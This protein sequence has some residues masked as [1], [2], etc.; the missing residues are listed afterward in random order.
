M[1]ADGENWNDTHPE[2][3]T[4][5]GIHD[6]CWVIVRPLTFHKYIMVTLVPCAQLP[7][8]QQ[9]FCRMTCISAKTTV[10]VCF[11]HLFFEW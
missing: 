4:V 11:Q 7:G 1:E 10:L 3:F 2:E 9:D 5:S 8:K 6:V